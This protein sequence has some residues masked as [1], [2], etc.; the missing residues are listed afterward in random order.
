MVVERHNCCEEQVCGGN[1]K[2]NFKV[3]EACTIEHGTI[4]NYN[5]N[6]KQRRL[7][8]LQTTPVL[9]ASA[10]NEALPSTK[11]QRLQRTLARNLEIRK[12]SY[13]RLVS[14]QGS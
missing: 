10:N 8:S 4:D 1:T 3:T 5:V 9:P 7:H 14:T 13:D 11:L 6:H 2:I 12:L